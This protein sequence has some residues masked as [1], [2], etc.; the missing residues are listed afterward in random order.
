MREIKFRAWLPSIKKMTYNHPLE[1]LLGWNL[2]ITDSETPIWLQYTGLKDKNGKEI[3]EGD[4]LNIYQ[5]GHVVAEFAEGCYGAWD[6]Y[7]FSPFRSTLFG[8]G[9]EVIGNFYE[10]PELMA[11]T[12]D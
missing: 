4:V 7:G 9:G 2:N 6:H 12:N 3:Y 11:Y 8:C 10:N 5:Y 1:E